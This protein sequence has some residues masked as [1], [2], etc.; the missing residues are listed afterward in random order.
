MEKKK[1]EVV[2]GVVK[3]SE[4]GFV[5]AMSPEERTELMKA[6]FDYSKKVRR[7][8]TLSEACLAYMENANNGP[9]DREKE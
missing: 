7:V 4:L 5:M 3:M 8:P 9:P 2:E 6:G 1:N